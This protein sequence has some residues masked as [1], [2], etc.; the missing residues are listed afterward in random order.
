MRCAIVPLLLASCSSPTWIREGYVVRIRPQDPEIASSSP[1]Y[2]RTV[3]IRWLGVAGFHIAHDDRAVLLPPLFSKQSVARIALAPLRVDEARIDR[4]LPPSGNVEA[5]LVGHAHYDHLLDVPYIMKKHATR[6]TAYGSRTTVNIL[7]GFGIPEARRVEPP[8]GVWVTLPSRRVRFAAFKSEHAPHLGRI[9]H[10]WT[11]HEEKPLARP[12]EF[13][14]QFVEGQ[15]LSYLIEFLDAQE[16]PIFTIFYQDCASTGG[17]GAPTI[18]HR[19]V[20]VAILC[21]PGWDNVD[22]YPEE[23]LVRLRP[24]HVVLCHYDDFFQDPDAEMRF[25]FH[26]DTEEFLREAQRVLK[27]HAIPAT[28]YLPSL[29]ARM[30][31]ALP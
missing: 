3:R 21:V 14:G 22:G 25:L 16:R 17:V 8:L 9:V 31:F 29:H 18:A 1:E 13:A 4:L 5:V 19:P 7:A 27:K 30:N 15:P 26:A 24:K 28:I 11:G 23:I 2:A 20:D 12:P 6:A 10:L